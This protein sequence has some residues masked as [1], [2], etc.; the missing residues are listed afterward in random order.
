MTAPKIVCPDC[1]SMDHVTRRQFMKTACAAGLASAALPGLAHAA[2]P[3]LSAA[4]AEQPESIVK[5]LYESFSPK[6]KETLCFAW[7]YQAPKMGL[8][9]TRVANN[10]HIT[11]PQIN[12]DFFNKDQK[13]MVRDIFEG[14]I[15][16]EWHARIDKQLDDDAGGFG[17]DQNVAIFGTPGDGKYEFVM[18]GRHMTMRC[19]GN[20][21]EHVAFGGP[22]FYGHAAASFDE[23]ADH[24]GNVYW[25]QAQEANKLFSMMD[26]RQQ[27]LALVAKSPRE[28]DS[29]FRGA[30]AELPG[31]PASELFERSAHRAA[32]CAASAHRAVPSKRSRRSGEVPQGAR[33]N[34]Q[35]LAGVLWRS[36]HR[37]RPRVGQLAA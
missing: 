27:K 18:T 37:Q 28:Q 30:K 7:D 31:I 16:P 11:K 3:S 36:R 13:R 21:T 14:I 20:S 5:L 26:T 9:R 1:D 24:K 6:Q 25:Y 10:W 17:E 29:G 19:D 4:S 12:S 22:I 35:V 8:L 34:R 15:Q 33:R 2:D 23:P 32:T